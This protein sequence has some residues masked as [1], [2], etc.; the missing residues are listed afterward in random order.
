MHS[1]YSN[2]GGAS[3]NAEYKH[4]VGLRLII[5]SIASAAARY[6]R[7]VTPL[8]SFSIDFYARVF[9]VVNTHASHVKDLAR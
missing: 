7:Y 4:E 2:Y 6:G 8:L 5:N 9:L 3:V 1:R